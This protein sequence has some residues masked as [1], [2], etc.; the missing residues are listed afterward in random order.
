MLI[1]NGGTF[2]YYCT[3]W[4]IWTA[5]G[6][7]NRWSRRKRKLLTGTEQI[8]CMIGYGELKY[9]VK[10]RNIYAVLHVCL[11]GLT[12]FSFF[13][14]HGKGKGKTR[15][16]PRAKILVFS[17]K[18]PQFDFPTFCFISCQHCI[19]QS[20]CVSFLAKR[21]VLKKNQL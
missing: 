19:I 3:H 12:S 20:G 9:F 6:R 21:F 7:T 13:N 5:C 8:R 16:V 14:L 1:T 11:S 17:F 2:F 4:N 10:S 18:K 15:H